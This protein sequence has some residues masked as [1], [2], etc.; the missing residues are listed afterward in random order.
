VTVLR[1]I[2]QNLGGF[3][4][5]TDSV[6]GDTQHV[7]FSEGKD[8][9]LAK[10]DKGEMVFNGRESSQLRNMGFD[11]R[12]SVIKALENKDVKVV[13][14]FQNILL[15]KKISGQLESMNKNL[16]NLEAGNIRID[17]VRDL[18]IHSATKNG[19]KVVTKSKLHGKR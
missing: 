12:D 17:D 19:R 3:Y 13:N 10:L 1:Q 11:T 15:Q 9:Y 2:A 16:R 5:G 7:K 18:L 4:E 8:G 14:S 6:G